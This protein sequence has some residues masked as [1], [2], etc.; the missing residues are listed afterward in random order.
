MACNTCG[1]VELS[2]CNQT[3]VIE[4][5]LPDGNYEV[6]VDRQLGR[7]IA[8]GTSVA[9]Q[10]SV[11]I[12]LFP[13]G[14]FNP[15]GGDYFIEIAGRYIFDYPEIRCVRATVLNGDFTQNVI[16]LETITL[17]NPDPVIQYP[18]QLV[19]FNLLESMV[20]PYAGLR[21]KYGPTPNV[22]VWVY[23]EEGQL[24]NMLNSISFD[25]YPVKTI[26]ADFGGLSSGIIIIS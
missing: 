24:V 14:F 18:S 15:Y 2:N 22:Q 4:N 6:H 11:P 12:S 3:L 8:E 20:I 10:L 26:T 17:P 23:N 9:G 13:K 7:W 16:S 5:G 1:F 21:S 19:E 25:G